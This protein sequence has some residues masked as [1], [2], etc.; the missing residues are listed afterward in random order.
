VTLVVLRTVTSYTRSSRKREGR[1][2]T[3]LPGIGSY[4]LQRR[5]K[6]EVSLV[7]V[8]V[9][10]VAPAKHAEQVE[11]QLIPAGTLVIVPTPARL[12][13]VRLAVN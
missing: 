4:Q 1:F 13:T 8:S 3:V 11:P 9:S 5:W 12:V 6:F 2:T 7:V 10:C